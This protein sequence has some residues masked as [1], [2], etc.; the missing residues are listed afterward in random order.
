MNRINNYTKTEVRLREVLS[1]NKDRYDLIIQGPFLS[2]LSE[3]AEEAV[4]EL[5]QAFVLIA[6]DLD[7]IKIST[8]PTG[9]TIDHFEQRCLQQIPPSWEELTETIREYPHT[10]HDILTSLGLFE[11]DLWIEPV[12]EPSD[13][14]DTVENL[15]DL[16]LNDRSS[17]NLHK[18]A[19]TNAPLEKECLLKLQG[20]ILDQSDTQYNLLI[21]SRNNVPLPSI[22]NSPERQLKWIERFCKA[23][24]LLNI[25]QLPLN[26]I[27]I[28]IGETDTIVKNMQGHIISKILSYT[29]CEARSL[30][31]R[32]VQIAQTAHD[33]FFSL[34]ISQHKMWAEYNAPHQKPTDQNNPPK[35]PFK[36]QEPSYFLEK[37]MQAVAKLLA[38]NTV[39]SASQEIRS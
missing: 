9:T 32:T 24:E 25:S 38:N 21:K 15:S 39:D 19:R 28:S 6:W 30:V 1:T 4:S 16:S 23:L 5:K 27:T 10:A 26:E 8:N 13:L 14:S 2:Q 18:K 36:V 33:I 17:P 11:H 3:E 35:R 37:G 31:E 22:A 20:V 7:P 34:G 12:V 29:V